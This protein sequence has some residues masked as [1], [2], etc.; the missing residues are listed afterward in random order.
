MSKKTRNIEPFSVFR[1]V[2]IFIGTPIQRIILT[3]VAQ[4]L[5]PAFQAVSLQIFG[6]TGLQPLG[7]VNGTII[8]GCFEMLDPMKFKMVQRLGLETGFR[9]WS[10][11]LK[12]MGMDGY[13]PK[14]LYPLVN[15]Y[16]KLMGKSS[17]V[18]GKSTNFLWPFSIAFCK[19]TRG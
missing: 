16:K 8:S 11:C 15:V 13:G 2:D 14:W 7:V 12:W 3:G 1:T 6:L 19:F 9:I 10:R 4:T 5:L 17:F 18:I